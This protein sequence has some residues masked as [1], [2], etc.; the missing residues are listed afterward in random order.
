MLHPIDN[1]F[2]KHEEPA[3]SCLQFLREFI[4]QSDKRITEEWKYGMPFYCYNGKMCLYLWFHKKYKVP[5]I[6][7]V[8]GLKIDHKDLIKEK[9]ARMKIFLIDPTKDIPVKKI[10]S[11][12]KDVISLY[13]NSH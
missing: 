4:K 11:I 1:Y 7:I 6:G 12:L 3:R 2:L 5:Y 10:N 8:E 13:K 9:R